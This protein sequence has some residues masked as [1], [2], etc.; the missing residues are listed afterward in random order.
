M[1]SIKL[2][3]IVMVTALIL[4]SGLR[5]SEVVYQGEWKA[6]SYFITFEGSWQIL[7]Q[8]DQY[9]I[10]MG[11]DFEAKKAP[12][13]KIF[14]SKLPLNEIDG[15][16]AADKSWSVLVAPLSEYKGSHRCQVPDHI[17]V[18]DYQTIIVHCEKYAKLWG[19]A[20]L[21]N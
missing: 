7:K 1:N 11:D 13:L 21:K 20:S 17:V 19:G 9:T 8:Q 5:Q 12:D 15:D 2:N 10:V 18:D 14:L 6:D 4:L 3:T 16:N